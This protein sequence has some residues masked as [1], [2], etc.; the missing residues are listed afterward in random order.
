MSNLLQVDRDK[1]V[2]ILNLTTSA[3]PGERDAAIL[4]ANQFLKQR[5]V[6]WDQILAIQPVRNDYTKT[7]HSQKADA[8]PKSE[9]K[10]SQGANHT[11]EQSR[12]DRNWERFCEMDPARSEWID[13]NAGSLDFAESLYNGVR[14][15]GRLTPRQAAA[16]DKWLRNQ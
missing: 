5:G 9:S 7:E 3:Q 6:T 1:L 11:K 8:Q 14:K 13:D 4:K 10:P 2:K 16:V 12:E 15:Y